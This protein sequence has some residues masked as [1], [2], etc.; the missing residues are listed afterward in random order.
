[1]MWRSV[2]GLIPV[3]IEKNEY[4]ENVPVDGTPREVMCDVKSVGAREF[5]QAAAVGMKPEIIIAVRKVEYQD[6]PKLRYEGT[7]YHVVRT[8]S[9]NGE[10]LELT[11]SRFPMGG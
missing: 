11:C 6:E 10:V 2:V 3:T 1:M 9:K 7:V 5:Y 4:K 8:Y